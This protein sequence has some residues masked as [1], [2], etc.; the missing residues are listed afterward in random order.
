MVGPEPRSTLNDDLI[1]DDAPEAKTPRQVVTP[2]PIP[3]P[4]SPPEEEVAKL[5]SAQKITEDRVQL[6]GEVFNTWSVKPKHGTTIEQMLDPAYWAHTSRRLRPLD[7]LEAVSEDG[8]WYAEFI[9]LSQGDNWARVHVLRR[10][11]LADSTPIEDA[12][13]EVKWGGPARNFMV[14]RRSDSAI[15][16]KDLASAQVAGDWIRDFV[17]NRVA[18]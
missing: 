2:E 17:G 12:N 8:S 10:V 11:E 5:T 7:R 14:V 6:A 16:V 4:E 18:A 3:A 13:H 1:V 9:V 15:L